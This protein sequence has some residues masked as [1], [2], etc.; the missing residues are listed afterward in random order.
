MNIRTTASTA[1]ALALLTTASGAFDADRLTIQVGFPPGASYDLLA[2]AMANRIGPFL[3]GDPQVIVEN[4]EGAGG[5]RLLNLYLQT[6][7][8]DGSAVIMLSPSVP[9]DRIL[10]PET[11]TYD[12]QTFQYIVSLG[13]SPTYCVATEASGIDSFDK[14]LTTEGVVMASV[15]TSSTYYAAVAIERVFDVDFNV[16]TG[17]RGVAEVI[18]ALARGEADAFC[19]ISSSEF[20]RMRAAFD[21]NVVVEL[22]PER[23]GAIEGVDFILDR[24]EDPA[25]REALA[26]IFFSNRIRFPV[27]AHPDT[28]PET[29]AIL[30]DAF[31]AVATDPAFM[32][33]VTRLGIELSVTPGAEVQTLVEQLYQTDPGIQAAA[34]ALVQ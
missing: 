1:L 34:R 4:V 23:F 11:T 29:V 8:H 27:V 30:R 3:P 21:M 17:F 6:G 20:E 18:L 13:D 7:A 32:D 25:T 31:L 2:R 12:P 22:S 14:L 24:V 15:G 9:L 26:L 19:G 10:S 16:V 5:L 28:P 33:E